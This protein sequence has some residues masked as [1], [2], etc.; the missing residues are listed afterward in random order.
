MA[1]AFIVLDDEEQMLLERI[2]LDKE[3]DEALRF[4]EKHIAP[5]VKK[6]MPCMAREIMQF[7]R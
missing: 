7:Q 1:K 3:V 2:C 5:K 6:D 4:L